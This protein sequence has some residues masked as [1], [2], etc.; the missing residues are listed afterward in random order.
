M[1]QKKYSKPLP[2]W[3][4]F[5]RKIR[6]RGGGRVVAHG[7]GLTC[8]VFSMVP[9]SGRSSRLKQ[10]W[11]TGRKFVSCNGVRTKYV[12]K[13]LYRPKIIHIINY[14]DDILKEKGEIYCRMYQPAC[15][16]NILSSFFLETLLRENIIKNYYF[17]Y[18]RQHFFREKLK[19]SFRRSLYLT[20]G[21][22][23]KSELSH[24]FL[25]LNKFLEAFKNIKKFLSKEILCA[26]QSQ[27]E[28]APYVFDCITKRQTIYQG[29]TLVSLPCYRQP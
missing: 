5:G 29:T 16:K 28:T 15:P 26:S 13:H 9:Y 12:G 11:A 3:Q 14:S 8:L 19:E 17:Y 27:Q 25:T 24:T 10:V 18:R 2:R 1:N 7:A 23:N 22:E 4:L 20:S 6:G 21:T